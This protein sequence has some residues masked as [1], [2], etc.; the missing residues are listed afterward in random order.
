MDEEAIAPFG[1]LNVTSTNA[2]AKDAASTL[3]TNSTKALGEGMVQPRNRPTFLLD[4]G[5]K[6]GF[7]FHLFRQIVLYV[8]AG[9]L[10]RGKV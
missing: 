4:W 10:G 8:S 1:R 3:A 9:W 6:C 5:S 2:K 7:L